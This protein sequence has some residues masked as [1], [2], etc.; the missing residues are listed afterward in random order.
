M[1]RRHRPDTAT[2]YI[3]DFI[4][5][6]TTASRRDLDRALANGDISPVRYRIELHRRKKDEGR[7][8]F[9]GEVSGTGNKIN[10]RPLV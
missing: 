4:R 1:S 10:G 5:R 3:G 2:A 6:I 8:V 9:A 7:C